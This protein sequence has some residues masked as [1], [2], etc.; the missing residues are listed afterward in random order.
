MDLRLLH[1]FRTVVSAGSV[2][3]A[4]SVLLVSQPALSRQVQQLER[5]VGVR[6]FDRDRGRLR[7]TVAGEVFLEAAEEVLAAAENA[8][9]VAD[10][11]R[12]GRLTRVRMAAP[13]T[14][15]T[16]V[17]APFLAT[18]RPDDPLITVTEAHGDEALRGIGS[19]RDLAIL[20]V[21]PPRRLGTR[22]VAVLPVWAYVPA[23]HPLAGR[24]HLPVEELADHPLVLLD[25]SFRPRTL[26]D[27]ALAA[28]GRTAAAVVEC[29][30]PQVAQ[31]LAAAGRG[32][33]VVSDD[34]RFDLVPLRIGS[35][36]ASLRLGLH[37]A[38]D[39]R[40]HAA[41]EL[42]ALADRLADFCLERYGDQG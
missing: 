17:L 15:L 14:T 18:L 21:P 29:D 26:V 10:A 32:I 12:S 37:A 34:P 1:T 25:R 27:E 22:V 33:A 7:L 36:P 4:A 19:D 41:A 8:R 3:A 38:W 2:S 6:L 23:T 20:T 40:H 16:D 11:L 13:T 35:G 24:S 30:D 5:Q 9:S 39:P 31:A 28:V 42:A